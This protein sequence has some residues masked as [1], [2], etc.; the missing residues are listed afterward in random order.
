MRPLS[1]AADFRFG[2][3][4]AILLE[5]A[6]RAEAVMPIGPLNTSTRTPP[7]ERPGSMVN[8]PRCDPSQ[9]DGDFDDDL[10]R[11]LASIEPND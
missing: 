4:V 11:C 9:S 5:G 2:S 7:V 1:R 10:R 8:A 6:Y 3:E